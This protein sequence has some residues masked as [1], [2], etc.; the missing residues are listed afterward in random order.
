MRFRRQICV[1]ALLA[2]SACEEDSFDAEAPDCAWA[3][4]EGDGAI[5]LT[6]DPLSFRVCGDAQ[7]WVQEEGDPVAVR[8][9][10]MVTTP[11]AVVRT[12]SRN[13]VLGVTPD[14]PGLG[15]IVVP[16]LLAGERTRNVYLALNLDP[17]TFGAG[18]FDPLD[19]AGTSD[20]QTSLTL[21]AS[22]RE[23]VDLQLHFTNL[24]SGAWSMVPMAPGPPPG[25]LWPLGKAE[26]QFSVDGTLDWVR[27][28]TFEDPLLTGLSW[29]VHFEAPADGPRG[30]RTTSVAGASRVQAVEQDGVAAS[31]LSGVALTRRGEMLGFGEDGRTQTLGWLL[32][33]L[34][35][36]LVPVVSSGAV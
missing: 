7:V 26:L 8:E 16:Q 15:L 25:V 36:W 12:E 21:H 33:G 24:G 34:E 19:P 3:D 13:L 18:P 6:E 23:P 22:D 10:S 30:F 9:F 17:S 14:D 4:D 2:L 1:A 28:G 29:E 5:E 32:D 11:A 27:H 20:Y 31:R 35:G